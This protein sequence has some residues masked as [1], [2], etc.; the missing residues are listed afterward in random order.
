MQV[1]TPDGRLAATAEACKYNDNWLFY[2]PFIPLAPKDFY[3][4]AA[5]HDFEGIHLSESI[6]TIMEDLYPCY[7]TLFPFLQGELEQA[8]LLPVEHCFA[9]KHDIAAS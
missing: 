9:S 2:S 5:P 4:T 8:T 7:A 1:Y 6:K 3:S